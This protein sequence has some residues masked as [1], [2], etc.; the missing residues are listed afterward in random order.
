MLSGIPDDFKADVLVSNPPYVPTHVIDE[1]DEEVSAHEPHLALDGGED[2]MDVFRRLAQD[3]PCVLK[4]HGAIVVELF[5]SK[6]DVAREILEQDGRWK[7]IEIIHDLT[8][9]PRH[10]AA[11]LA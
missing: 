4:P 10:I 5:E 8:G 7:D 11:R 2:G 1:I 6:L 3:A 9:R